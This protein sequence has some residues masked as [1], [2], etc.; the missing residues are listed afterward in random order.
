MISGRNFSLPHL[1]IF[2]LMEAKINML[3]C[4]FTCFFTFWQ[5]YN[6]H[7]MILL[8]LCYCE[9]IIPFK[10]FFCLQNFIKNKILTVLEQIFLILLSLI[11]FIWRK[12]S[13]IQFFF[14]S[15]SSGCLYNFIRI[16]I[17]SDTLLTSCFKT[18]PMPY[19]SQ[20]FA[21]LICLI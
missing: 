7:C 19:F 18:E 4:F 8:V 20:L 11:Q 21:S 13:T 10:F 14:L 5:M 3:A 2:L 6:I 12:T 15:L 1:N 17:S 9:K 16:I